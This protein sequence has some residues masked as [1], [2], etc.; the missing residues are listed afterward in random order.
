[1]SSA[2]LVLF[3][4][5]SPSI[6][7]LS[8]HASLTWPYI[9]FWQG[10]CHLCISVSRI[11]LVLYFSIEWMNALAN[12][13]KANNASYLIKRNNAETLI[14]YFIT[15][16]KNLKLW[17]SS[18]EAYLSDDTSLRTVS[19]LLL[20]CQNSKGF[21]GSSRDYS[22][23][24]IA[25]VI[26]LIPQSDLCESWYSTREAKRDPLSCKQCSLQNYL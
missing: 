20:L 18:S 8:L 10:S 23:T 26:P 9:H 19:L 17:F 16:Q 4:L 21:S 13:L 11:Y 24:S 5:C 1:M 12:V 6:L 7:F 15:N 3:P 2:E 25:L 14:F 22:C